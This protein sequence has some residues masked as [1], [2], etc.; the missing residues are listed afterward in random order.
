MGQG[1]VASNF[2]DRGRLHSI[3]TFVLHDIYYRNKSSY[4]GKTSGKLLPPLRDKTSKE[5]LVIKL[6]RVCSMHVRIL[7]LETAQ[8]KC[9]IL[10]LCCLKT[11][12]KFTYR[13]VSLFI[14]FRLF[15]HC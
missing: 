6:S 8:E 2:P 15:L 9:V 12:H 1:V 3:I 5:F 4:A 10:Q 11:I 14:A 13:I 7:C